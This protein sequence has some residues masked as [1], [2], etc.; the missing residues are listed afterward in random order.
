MFDLMLQIMGWLSEEESLK[1]SER[2]KLAIKKREGQTYSK[3]GNKWGRKPLSQNVINEVL[4][5]HKEGLS[6]RQITKQ[7]FYWDKNNNKKFVSV[8]GVHKII[9]GNST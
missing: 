7:A 4:K 6:I 5:L 9:K 3:F 2:V 8:A 1:K